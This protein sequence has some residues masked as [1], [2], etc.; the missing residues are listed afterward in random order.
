MTQEKDYGADYATQKETIEGTWR[1]DGRE[2][3]LET[4][5]VTKRTLDLL[6]EYMALAQQYEEGDVPE[7]AGDD[8]ED[9]PWESEGDDRDFI[10]SVVDEKLHKPD[11]DVDE[12]V[13]RKLSAIFVGMFEAWQEGETVKAAREEMPVEGGN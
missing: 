3:A 11:I 4:E 12:T 10:E 1:I 9:F 7:G 2:F 13:S 6:G 5:D 8:L